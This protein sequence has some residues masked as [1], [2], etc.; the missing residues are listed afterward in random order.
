MSTGPPIAE[1]R[2]F[3]VAFR[4][5]RPARLRR[6]EPRVC[7]VHQ[8]VF[9]YAQLRGCFLDLPRGAE[10][11]RQVIHAVQHGRR[12]EQP[13]RLRGVEPRRVFRHARHRLL[14]ASLA[15]GA[16]L[17]PQVRQLLVVVAQRLQQE[18]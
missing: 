10:R 4:A 18:Q 5:R 2:S 13:R 17:A 12:P 9:L 3:R 7:V 11:V 14:L 1:T 15:V 8:K 6:A 16:L